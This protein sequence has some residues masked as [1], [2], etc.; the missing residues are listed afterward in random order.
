MKQYKF[1]L[2]GFIAAFVMAALMAGMASDIFG[3]VAGVIT[4]AVA[5]GVPVLKPFLPEA[6]GQRRM[7]ITCMAVQ[8]EVWEN[9]IEGNLFKNNEFLLQSTDES[10][11]V[12]AGKVVHIP[13]SGGLPAISV[14]AAFGPKTVIQRTDTDVTYN[15]DVYSSDP[16][17]ITEAE[18]VESSYDKR[19]SILVEHEESLN[20]AIADYILIKWA[21]ATNI[22]R[23]TGVMRNDPA[24]V[25]S[26]LANTPAAAGNR[27]KFGLWDLKAVQTHMDNAKVPR[28]DRFALLNVDMYNQL[29]DDLIATKYRDASM[30]FDQATG[31]IRGNL[32]GFQIYKRPTALIYSNANTPAVKAYGA[33]GAA[34]DN[35]A[36]L[37]W[38]KRGVGRAKGPTKFFQDQG[39]PIYQADI[40]SLSQ[41]MGARIRRAGEEFTVAMVQTAAA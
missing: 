29:V 2:L 22:M 12:L 23:T 37:F 20:E 32:M 35:A 24:N 13:Q 6:W 28:N 7:D 36:G 16:I 5:F 34:D 18:T 41:R 1:K 3:P 26:V 30:S 25:E 19:E 31:E 39:N 9:H 15:L 4:F 11:Y 27:L 14:N 38:Q 17:G 40:Y 21:P 33:A 10:Q 8:V